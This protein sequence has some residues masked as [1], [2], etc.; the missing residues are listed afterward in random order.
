[1]LIRRI[2][3]IFVLIAVFLLAF[4]IE[5]IGK[6]LY[7]YHYHNIITHQAAIHNLDPLF[8]AALIKT[9][10]NFNPEAISDA[11]AIGLLQIMPDTGKWIAKTRGINDFTPEKL[12]HPSTNIEMGTW[13]L[14]DLNKEFNNNKILVLAAYNAGRGNVTKW[15]KDKNLN[16]EINEINQIPFPETRHYIR[17]VLFNYQI[18]RYLYE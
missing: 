14:S 18:Y 2:L 16:G 5:K 13:Y 12:Y 3:Y 4:N 6:K 15:I 17:K 11:G 7:P 1:M 8:V 9:E 10:S